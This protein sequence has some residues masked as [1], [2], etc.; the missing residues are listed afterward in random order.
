LPWLALL[1]SADPTP[2]DQATSSVIGY[3]FNYG[4]L[5]IVT[6]AFAWLFYR[7]AP[8][9]SKNAHGYSRRK[10]GSKRNGTRHS[11]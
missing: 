8:T 5:G 7:P 3:V 9:S 11:G 1:A 10:L 6:V 4:I 2:V